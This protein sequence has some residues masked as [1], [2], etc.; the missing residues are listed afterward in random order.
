MPAL[1]CP[2]CQRANPDV[3]QYCYFDGAVLRGQQDGQASPHRLA[4]EF[5]FPSGRKCRTYDELAQGCQDEWVAARDLLKE[6]TF[7]QYFGGCGR[8]DLA[9]AAGEAMAEA[10]PDIALTTFLGILPV[11]QAQAPKLDINP[12]RLLLGNLLAGEHR[13]LQLIITNQG[14]GTLQGT[15]NITEGSDWIKL[16]GANPGQAAISTKR[17]QRV[18][19]KVDTKGVPAGGTFGARLTVISNGGVAEVLARMDLVAQPYPKGPFQGARTP[20]DLAEK[21]RKN[22]KAAG[23]ALESN[24]VTQWFKANGWNF[25]VQGPLAKG[26]GGVQQFFEAM[27]LSKPPPVQ[28]SQA[29]VRVSCSYPQSVRSQVALQTPAKKWVYAGITSDSPWLKVLTPAVSGPQQATIAFEVDPRRLGAGPAEGKLQI[30]ANAGQKLAVRVLAQVQGAPTR[31]TG[32]TASGNLWPSVLAFAFMFLLLRMFLVPFV[33]F[34]G[35]GRVALEA[36]EKIGKPSETNPL[37]EAGGWLRLPWATILMGSREPIPNELFETPPAL[38]VPWVEFRDR[39]GSYFIRYL[40]T[41][42]WWV[43]AVLGALLVWR[44][45]GGMSNLPWGI[46]AGAVAGVAGSATLAS[47]YLVV[48]VVPHF[49]WGLVLGGKGNALL[50]LVWVVVALVGWAVIGG[51]LGLLLSRVPPLERAI[52]APVRKMVDGLFRLCGLRGLAA[53]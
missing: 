1:V 50:L 18:I 8:A 25:P 40:V 53:A 44:R 24:E 30:V 23:P 9:R 12:R 6:G 7:K 2:R 21:M 4:T 48:E 3:A 37:S 45:G 42:S 13:N 11:S 29:E 10:D 31:P 43:G 28:V 51:L 14:Q 5:V 46:L 19:L 49:L 33:D 27:G 26:V 38:P 17:E 15:L 32:T 35:R 52:V 22:P 47:A 41:W 39:F 34:G 16:D 36:F 20:R